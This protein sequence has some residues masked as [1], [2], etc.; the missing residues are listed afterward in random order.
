[1]NNTFGVRV[2]D[3]LD[4][5]LHYSQSIFL[6]KESLLTCSDYV[7]EWTTLTQLG[8]NIIPLII[9]IRS[10]E[11]NQIRMIKAH[12]CGYLFLDSL[13]LLF[14]YLLVNYYFYG[15]MT[16]CF[17]VD[18]FTDTTCL[19]ITD[20]LFQFIIILELLIRIICKVLYKVLLL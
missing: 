5:L 1:M 10:V 3:S 6:T 9:F 15:A 17:A 4:E 13:C 2:T 19:A 11:S 14:A 16:P 8:N 7:K 12:Q 20:D 18:A